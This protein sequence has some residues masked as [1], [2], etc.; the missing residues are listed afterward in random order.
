MSI[1]D[2]VVL[3]GTLLAIVGFG[4]W[5]TRQNQTVDDYLRG[6][7]EMRWFTIGLSVMATQA[8]AITFLSAPGLGYEKGLRFVQ[9]YFGLPLALIIISAFIIPIYYRLKVYT[10]YEY[11]ENR[12]DIKTRLLA[13]FLFL[14]Q[15]GLAAGLTIFAPAIILSTLLGWNLNFTNVFVGV[16]VI[17]YT[18]SGG[19][20]A[21]SLTQKWQ[22]GVI[23]LGMGVAFGI[24]IYKIGG[25]VEMGSAMNLAGSVG[26]LEVLDFDFNLNERY[27]VW[28]GLTGGLFLAL[29]YFGTDQS[30]VQ[31]YLTGKNIKESR[32]GLMFNAIIK[33][34]MQFFILFTGVLV[35]VF[36]LYVQPPVFFNKT[37]IENIRGSEYKEKLEDLETKYDAH[38]VELQTVRDNFVENDADPRAKE[39]FREVVARDG[40]IRDEVK[41]LLLEANPDFKVKDTNYVFLTFVMDYL[42]IGVVGLII[43]L[44]FSAAMSSTAGELNALAT[45]TSVDFYRR[46]F[47]REASEKHQ[48]WMSKIL[49]VLWGCLAIGFALTATLFDNLI[50]MVNVLGSLF[51]GTILGIFV[52]AFFI[53]KVKGNAVFYSALIAEAFVLLIHFGRVYEI[54]FF[55]KY[56]VEY[57]W[58]NVI[59]CVAVVVLSL[60]FTL[61]AGFK[62][63]T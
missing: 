24:L 28:S 55:V 45:T 39:Q 25:F 7:N 47:N 53:K 26:R 48:V 41:S 10:A 35:F 17:I 12:F 23:L 5:K 18:V 15:R 61:A 33:I 37:A 38:F 9:F 31:R 21:V 30:Q 63:S 3:F 14:V 60:L 27:T 50:E 34:P 36:Y 11:L 29:S 16:L 6:G 4:V 58:Y 32:L 44:I 2:W 62:K 56:E 52:V 22:M 46:L 13:A 43:A 20:K 49:T 57:L 42:P 8:S 1:L 59:G 51:Y 40:E 54:P 19:T